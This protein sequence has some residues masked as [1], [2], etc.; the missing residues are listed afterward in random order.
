M[1]SEPL[2]DRVRDAIDAFAVPAMPAALIAARIAAERATVAPNRR[3]GIAVAGGIALLAAAHAVG[4]RHEIHMPPAYY[5]TLKRLTGHDF[6]HARVYQ[7]DHPRMTLAQARR[8][9]SFPIVV[10][11]G[12]RVLDIYPYPNDEGATLVLAVDVHAQA[13]L[14]EHW[15]GA[16]RPKWASKLEG[17]GIH[18]DGSIRRFN[19]R[20][21]RIGRIEFSTPMYTL[22]YHR[23]AQELERATREAAAEASKPPG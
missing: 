5:A 10:P 3:P 18:D 2:A 22:E 15:A 1:T 12:K 13:Q 21:W 20:W 23:Y 9:T 6:S 17:V 8:H 19:I 11:R 16:K 14:E 7:E 4:V